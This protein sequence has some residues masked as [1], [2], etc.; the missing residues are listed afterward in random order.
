MPRAPQA[1]PPPTPPTPQPPPPQA[2]PAPT[3]QGDDLLVVV[4]LPAIGPKAQVHLA[5]P[6]GFVQEP[7]EVGDRLGT[8]QI[9]MVD[10]RALPMPGN[11]REISQSR[12]IVKIGRNYWAVE[13][14]QQLGQRRILRSQE[15]PDALKPRPARPKAGS[16]QRPPPAKPK[17]AGPATTQPTL[18]AS[19]AKGG[20]G[21]PGGNRIP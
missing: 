19:A 11:P 21:Q 12:V 8:G 15:L 3:P 7:L 18:E 16:A 14:G 17:S 4:G 6:G 20:A 5:S 13:L 1:P 9:A 2:P 10:Y